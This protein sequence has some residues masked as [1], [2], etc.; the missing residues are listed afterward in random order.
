MKRLISSSRAKS[1]AKTRTSVSEAVTP[2]PA[3]PEA[4]RRMR[5]EDERWNLHKTVLRRAAES[6]AREKSLDSRVV[7]LDSEEDKFQAIAASINHSSAEVRKE[8][9]RKLYSLNPDRAASFFNIA[10]QQSSVRERRALGVALASS[11]LVDQAL[12]HLTAHNHQDCY[13]AFSLLFLLAKSGE[14]QPLIK[15]IEQHPNT[16]VRLAVIRLLSASGEE[17]VISAFRQLSVQPSL[18][19]ELRSAMLDAV[20]QVSG[21]SSSAA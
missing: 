15:V 16:Q 19:H 9:V 1:V 10:L 7:V 17:E 3:Q 12:Q 11:G 14:V 8:V 21:L 4:P 2:A 13:G 18:A 20:T 5:A 6:L